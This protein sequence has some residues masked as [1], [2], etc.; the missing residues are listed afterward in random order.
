MYIFSLIDKNVVIVSRLISQVI[1][2]S[3]I[4]LLLGRDTICVSLMTIIRDESLTKSRC[5]LVSCDPRQDLQSCPRLHTYIQL[6][7][8]HVVCLHC[9]GAAKG[10]GAV[11]GLSESLSTECA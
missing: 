8:K 5:D 7:Y 11:G 9:S 3:S 4:N 1:I 2:V 10:E 6:R